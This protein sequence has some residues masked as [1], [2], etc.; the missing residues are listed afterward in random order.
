MRQTRHRDVKTLVG[1]R[2][3]ATAFVANV[4]GRVGL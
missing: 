2:R 1:Y 3:H 4:S